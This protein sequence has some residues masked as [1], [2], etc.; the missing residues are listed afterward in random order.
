MQITFQNEYQSCCIFWWQQIFKFLCTSF[1]AYIP[2]RGP[3][4]VLMIMSTSPPPLRLGIPGSGLV[5]Q[6]QF[7]VPLHFPLN[8]QT[9]QDEVSYLMVHLNIFQWK[10]KNF[11]ILM[12]QNLKQGK[13]FI[14]FFL[15]NSLS[16]NVLVKM[17]INEMHHKSRMTI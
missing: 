2:D 10:K 4:I 6:L 9:A 14:I 16:M 15:E 5:L 17:F 13:G 12:D 7:F 11:Q 3:T 1:T 8:L